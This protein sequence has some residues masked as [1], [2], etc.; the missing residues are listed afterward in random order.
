MTSL[1][2]EPDIGRLRIKAIQLVMH[3]YQVLEIPRALWHA[4][5]LV[6]H[7]SDECLHRLAPKIL[8]GSAQGHNEI[9][10]GR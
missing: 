10:E 9:H 3:H 1:D 5:W 8:G 6:D 7:V 2:T 4:K